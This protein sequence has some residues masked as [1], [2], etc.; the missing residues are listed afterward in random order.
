ME[1]E[2]SKEVVK[3]VLHSEVFDVCV[4]QIKIERTQKAMSGNAKTGS[5]ELSLLTEARSKG[6]SFDEQA[7][8]I[9]R[10]LAGLIDEAKAKL[11]REL[12]K[13][14]RAKRA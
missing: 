12:E 14:Y 4:N 8:Y 6:L 10:G 13:K 9:Y 2:K 5:K 7:L 3:D 11:N 1:K